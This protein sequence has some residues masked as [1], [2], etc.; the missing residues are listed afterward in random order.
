MARAKNPYAGTY[1]PSKIGMKK[2]EFLKG[3]EGTPKG[4]FPNRHMS[5]TAYKKNLKKHV[6]GE[7]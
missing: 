1:G 4:K 3:L 6:E 2:E 7:E 5:T